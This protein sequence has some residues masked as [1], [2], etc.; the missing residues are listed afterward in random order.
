MT[1]G[2]FGNLLA[3]NLNDTNAVTKVRDNLGLLLC[4]IILFM[5]FDVLQS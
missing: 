3:E 4:P 2:T 5:V 1:T